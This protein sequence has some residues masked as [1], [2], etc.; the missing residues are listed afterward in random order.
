MKE[1][2]IAANDSGQRVDKFLT[3]AAPLLPQSLRLLNPSAVTDTSPVRSP[4]TILAAASAVLHAIPT[5]L[6]ATPALLLTTLFAIRLL[7]SIKVPKSI[8]NALSSPAK[9]RLG[10]KNEGCGLNLP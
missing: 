5:A 10:S 1:F 4:T 7:Y 6:A 9:C 2:I 8:I 3:K